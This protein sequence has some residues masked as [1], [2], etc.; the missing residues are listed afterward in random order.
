[1]KYLFIYLA[2]DALLAQFSLF[3]EIV[4]VRFSSCGGAMRLFIDDDDD[5]AFG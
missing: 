3:E 1:M 5:F 4:A 2:D